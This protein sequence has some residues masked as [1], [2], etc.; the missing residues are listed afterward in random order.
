MP[1]HTILYNKA[2]TAFDE[3]KNKEVRKSWQEKTDSL[4]MERDT[5]KLWNRTK[6]LNDNQQHAPR[7]VLL[8]ES[9]HI[10]TGKKA[11]YL[12]ADSFR[13]DSLL[14]ISREK[15]A[16]IRMKT[17]EQLQKQ[18]P[19]PSMTFEFYIHELNCAIRQ[20]KKRGKNKTRKPQGRM[21]FPMR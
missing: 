10:F 16:D 14:D 19:V 8:K 9:T 3:E 15:Q 4:N 2:R 5:Q 11:A 13:E 6:A 1:E 17:K 18:S 20:L 21:T 7:T 12:L